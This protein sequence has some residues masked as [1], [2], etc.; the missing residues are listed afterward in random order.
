MSFLCFFE[1]ETISSG[2]SYFLITSKNNDVFLIKF[3]SNQE[4]EGVAPFRREK[5]KKDTLMTNK[6]NDGDKFLVNL[7][8]YV[9]RGVHC[10]Q[11]E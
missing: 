1:N 4:L 6:L 9:R 3:H 7:R 11:S 5:P 2:R 8:G 10:Y